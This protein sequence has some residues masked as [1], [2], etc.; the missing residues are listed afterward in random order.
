MLSFE[1]KCWDWLEKHWTAVILIG[2]V[3]IALI[4]R[5]S[6]RGYLSNDMQDCLIPW[7]EEIRAGG[8]LASLSRPVGNYNVPYQTLI[9]LFTLIPLKPIYLYKLLSC[10]FDL[11]QA[12]L[13][14]RMVLR[15]GKKPLTAAIAFGIALNLPIVVFNSALWGQCDSIFTFFGLLALDLL[16][17]E[18]PTR[19]WIALGAAFAFK[20]QAVFLLPFFLFRYVKYRSFTLLQILWIP[21][22]MI[23]LSLGG[24]LQ[25]LPLPEI[26]QI[27]LGQ[28]SQF[29]RMSLCYPGFWNFLIQT[30]EFD[31]YLNL[32]RYAILLT[33][34][35]LALIMIFLLRSRKEWTGTD[36]FRVALLMAY[37]CV[38][39]LPAMHERYS[40]PCLM[41]GL[42]LCFLDP[43]SVPLFLGLMAIDL[44]TYS[45]YL[46]PENPPFDWRYLA[47]LNGVCYAL[48]CHRTLKG[49]AVSRAGTPVPAFRPEKPAPENPAPAQNAPTTEKP[50]PVP[51]AP[52]AEKPSPAPKKAPSG[53]FVRIRGKERRR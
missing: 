3:L 35:A 29:T 15:A 1:R 4:A 27:Y 40:Y 16:R 9:A 41:L 19:A 14:G 17:R 51:S 34:L 2:S 48:W 38:Y 37:T 36:Y 28:T 42:L 39:F 53:P 22:M 32:Y 10:L 6:M 31:Y 49:F 47:L 25:G 50:S 52:A 46:F 12:A 18:K 5:W 20:L 8:G 13:I 24:I 7:Y 23:L 26:F 43:R 44:S 11:L 30:E 45:A 33:V 21:A